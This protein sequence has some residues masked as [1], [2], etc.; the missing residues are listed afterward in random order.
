MF[1]NKFRI[2]TYTFFLFLSQANVLGN[3]IIGGY[4]QIKNSFT[5]V[6]YTISLNLHVY[7]SNGLI[8]ANEVKVRM[9]RKSDGKEVESF[10]LQ[11]K[12]SKKKVYK[13]ATCIGESGY[14]TWYV[15]YEA[16]VKMYPPS[17]SDPEG[18]YIEWIDCC[19]QEA[20]GNL[21]SPE[22]HSTTLRTLFPPIMYLN[23]PFFNS[24]PTIGALPKLLICKN[25]RFEYKV[26]ASDLE[27]DKLRFSLVDPL[28]YHLRS[29]APLNWENGY[30]AT[31]AIMGNPKLSIDPK[32]GLISVFP[33]TIGLFVF[34]VCVEELRDG[35]RIGEAV[36]E[37]L[38]EVID[39]AAT[40]DADENVYL[41]DKPVTST[42]ICSGSSVVLNAKTTL[43]GQCQWM[44]N[45][46]DIPGATD[47]NLK[48]TKEGEYEFKV[49]N[50][51]PCAKTI[52]S[53]KAYVAETNS[54]FKLEKHST[55]TSCE[56]ANE[57]VLV[58]P[59]NLHY[60]YIWF[61]DNSLLANNSN[62]LTVSE[63]G[64]YWAVV[65]SSTC[66]LLSDTIEIEQSSNPNVKVEF[67]PVLHDCDNGNARITLVGRPA[68]GI[69]QG[70]GV[71][72]NLFDPNQAGIGLHELTY[73]I[74]S[75][76]PCPNVTA[77]QTV[78][79]LD[80]SKLSI[81]DAFTPNQDGI[82]DRWELIGIDKY[83]D[84]EVTIFNRWGNVIFHSKGYA[85]PFDGASNQVGVYHYKIKLNE[86][87]PPRSGPLMLIR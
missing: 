3:N 41:D 30:N 77:R 73:S 61:R 13:Q 48:V 32:T 69:F 85:K 4:L 36:R 86:V 38:L 81:P 11:K 16:H 35:R 46:V 34:A 40:S 56:Q 20:I 24:T 50:V 62:S 76:S 67:E 45:G 6:D 54:S 59:K 43:D 80:C 49:F 9:I 22:L 82:N 37:Y 87:L 60:S 84:A 25:E 74:L 7:E 70:A 29:G 14:H 15:D 79:V 66:K 72:N 17:Y 63:P 57:T 44:L 18:Y 52:E 47:R 21:Q 26:E 65:E 19:R 53:T 27:G 12:S 10:K 71:V 5:I 55:S 83:P 8:L 58:G 28:G 1:S 2:V 78:A 64:N 23:Y 68:G 75:P 31:N 51:G 33:K 39:C 42:T